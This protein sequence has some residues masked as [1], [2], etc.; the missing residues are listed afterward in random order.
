M[1]ET[2]N[3]PDHKCDAW[4]RMQ[5][6]WE[7]VSDVSKGTL[8][9]RSLK[10]RYLPQFPAEHDKLY[11][12]RLAAATLFNAYAR[13][14]QGLVGMVFKKN[15]VLGED[16][17]A[18]IRGDAEKNLEGHAENIDLA[19]THLDVFARRVLEDAFEGHAFILVD[20]QQALEPGATLEDEIKSGR[21]PY[22][23][24]YKV[25]QAV[26][27]LPVTINGRV[28]IGLITFEEEIREKA[29][30]YGSKAVKQYRTFWLEGNEAGGIVVRWE[31]KKLVREE[32]KEETFED[33]GSGDVR[34]FTRI[35][36]GVVYGKRTGFLESQPVA[37]DLALLNVK[38]WQKQSDRDQSLHKCG[39]PIPLFTGVPE[40]WDMIVAGSGYG[41]K[42]PI[43]ADGKYMEPEGTAL[44]ASLED[45]KELRTEMAA[46]GLSVLAARPQVERTATET[47]IDFSQESSEL[48]LMA[49]SLG[50]ALELC[51]GFHAKYLG[52]NSGGSVGVGAHLRTVR[53]TEAQ[54]N[55]YASMAAQNGLSW[56]TVREIMQASGALPDTFNEEEEMSR[57][58]DQQKNLGE[59][60]L[61]DFDQGGEGGE[62]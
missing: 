8:H 38:Y 50:D 59:S 18:V 54:I 46:L 51:L 10:Q 32:G 60:L 4:Q 44:D 58:K 13:T 6:G 12:N 14:V 62:E 2:Y 41:L 15:P 30:R 17:P 5:R 34:G 49:R 11:Q 1:N 19:G 36:V 35:P 43:D 61:R 53:L 29:G 9:L 26:N 56:Q 47:A 37:L 21:R 28:E 31:L 3:R 22:W 55:A 16:V 7:I 23:V 33:A 52:E 39:N 40:D 20:M 27:F 45:L 48:E 24:K 57:I 42:L 25:G